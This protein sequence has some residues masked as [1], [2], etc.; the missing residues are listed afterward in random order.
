MSD[1]YWV[2]DPELDIVRIYRREGAHF[3]FQGWNC[4]SIEYSASSQ[5]TRVVFVSLVSFVVIQL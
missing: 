5:R 3:S 1:E 2:V 4:R